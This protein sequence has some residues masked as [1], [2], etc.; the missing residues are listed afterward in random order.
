MSILTH[1]FDMLVAELPELPKLQANPGTSLWEHR[2]AI[3]E[4]FSSTLTLAVQ[5]LFALPQNSLSQSLGFDE[6][7]EVRF[8]QL[9]CYHFKNCWSKAEVRQIIN[10]E[11]K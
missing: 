11:L 4:L 8:L 5:T 3:P 9:L 6:D 10:D 7:V 2:A 1:V